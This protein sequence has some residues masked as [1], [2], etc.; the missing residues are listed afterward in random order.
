MS[1][2]NLRTRR[3]KQLI[4]RRGPYSKKLIWM[5]EHMDHP[6]GLLYGQSRK[7]FITW[8]EKLQDCQLLADGLPALMAEVK[9]YIKNMKQNPFINLQEYWSLRM[10]LLEFYLYVKVI[11]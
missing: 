6:C 5:M 4:R 9:T 2:Y 3:P 7:T 10:A 1:K 8:L 11:M